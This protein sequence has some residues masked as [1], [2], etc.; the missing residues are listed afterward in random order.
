MYNYTMNQNK[1]AVGTHTQ[2]SATGASFANVRVA[3]AQRLAEVIASTPN[4]RE[5]A[6]KVAQLKAQYQNDVFGITVKV[7]E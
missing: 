1:P 3:W 4:P 2:P 7:E 5:R 6:A